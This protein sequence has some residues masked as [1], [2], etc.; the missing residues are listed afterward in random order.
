MVHIG[1]NGINK[2]RVQFLCLIK[3]KESLWATEDHVSNSLPQLALKTHAQKWHLLEYTRDKILIV[4]KK[5][6][7]KKSVTWKLKRF[8]LQLTYTYF[9]FSNLVNIAI[10]PEPIS[11]TQSCFC[12][13]DNKSPQPAATDQ[14]CHPVC[15]LLDRSTIKTMNPTTQ[16]KGFS[17]HII[18]IT[19][20]WFYSTTQN[21]GDFVP[22][23][24]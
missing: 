2:T 9:I 13:Q 4:K 14:I 16:I 15:Y 17:L 23:L 1:L 7:K 24:L 20:Q 6:P 18:G 3:N 12:L 8:Y 5:I 22:T 19:I 21:N 10:N 11:R